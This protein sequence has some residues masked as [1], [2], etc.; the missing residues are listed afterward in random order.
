MLPLAAARL[1]L[2]R[3]MEEWLSSGVTRN[4]SRYSNGMSTS[5]SRQCESVKFGNMW[6]VSGCM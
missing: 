4:V 5:L 6:I 2:P 3:S 1:R